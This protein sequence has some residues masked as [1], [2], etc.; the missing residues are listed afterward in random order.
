MR[1]LGLCQFPF[2]HWYISTGFF[3][4]L[5]HAFEKWKFFRSSLR[6]N[7]VSL[8]RTSWW[9]LNYP[10]CAIPSATSGLSNGDS[11]VCSKHLQ[12]FSDLLLR[13]T[14]RPHS[15][16]DRRA[17][18]PVLGV[19]RLCALCF[20]LFYKEGPKISSSGELHVRV[21]TINWRRGFCIRFAAAGGCRSKRSTLGHHITSVFM[22]HDLNRLKKIHRLMPGNIWLNTFT[23]ASKRIELLSFRRL[24][25][26]PPTNS[27]KNLVVASQFLAKEQFFDFWD[28]W[29]RCNSVMRHNQS[30]N[31]HCRVFKQ[32]TGEGTLGTF[33]QISCGW[34]CCMI[35]HQNRMQPAGLWAWGKQYCKAAPFACIRGC[36]QFL[37]ESFPHFGRQNERFR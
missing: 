24:R 5:N 36:E 8:R 25:T 28:S 1:I 14:K 22:L 35:C 20:C 32:M 2:S 7:P 27:K 33:C 6:R 10:I 26:L 16:S 12:A 9:K 29:S 23:S 34:I 21:V 11:L 19:Q 30:H 18:H 3:T 13:I 15:W 17:V 31:L 4:I 37:S